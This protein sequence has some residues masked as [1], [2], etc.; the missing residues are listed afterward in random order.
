MTAICGSGVTLGVSLK[1]YFGYARTHD[2]CRDV[3]VVVDRHPEVRAGSVRLFVLPSFPAIPGVANIF[4]NSPI[5]VGAQNA[6]SEDEGAFTGEVTPR[7]LAELGC[8]YIEIGHAERRR[9]FGEDDDV[10]AAKTAA[11]LRNGITPLICVGEPDHEDVAIASE[12][13]VGQLGRALSLARAAGLG[14][15]VAVAYE[16]YWAIGAAEPA[17]ADRISTVSEALRNALSADDLFDGAVLYGGSAG[18]GTLT[19]LDGS[20]DGLFLGRFAHD[21]ERLDA[22]IAEAVMINERS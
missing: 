12:F 2:W 13:C 19:A 16:P 7:M 4:E 10:V 17:P 21:P 8:R 5:E 3:R 6:Y 1:A 15:T 18:P 11:A 20:V 14:A 9:L 22:I